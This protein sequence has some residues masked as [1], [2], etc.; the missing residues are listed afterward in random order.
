MSQDRKLVLEPVIVAAV[1][2]GTRALNCCHWCVP[3]CQHS[4]TQ[5]VTCLQSCP[6]RA[7]H[8]ERHKVRCSS[9]WVMKRKHNCSNRTT[10]ISPTQLGRSQVTQ[11]NRKTASLGHRFF[12]RGWKDGSR[13]FLRAELSSC[14]PTMLR[15]WCT[16]TVPWRVTWTSSSFWVWA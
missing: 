2:M 3:H 8:R 5:R 10:K 16:A 13:T 6:G 15:W 1:E 12:R 14:P 4:Q 11:L 7:H 9:R